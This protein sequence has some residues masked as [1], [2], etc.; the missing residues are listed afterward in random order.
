VPV[1]LTWKGGHA[2]RWAFLI[3][4]AFLAVGSCGPTALYFASQRALRPDWKRRVSHLP[5][6]MLIGTGI[7]VSNAR[8][9][10]EALLGIK[11]GFVRT[12]KRNLTDGSARRVSTGYRLPVDPVFL[13]E[14]ALALYSA[15]GVSVYFDRGRYLIGPFLALYAA[16]FGYVALL[17]MGE[18]LRLMVRSA[19]ALAPEACAP[20]VVTVTAPIGGPAARRASP[21]LDLLEEPTA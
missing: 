13:V 10:F 12:P 18:R 7:A 20:T 4:G 19:P 5:L 8:A 11:S 3:M 14:A 17:S 1:L 15:W 2:P 9:V 6:L 21:S 16:S